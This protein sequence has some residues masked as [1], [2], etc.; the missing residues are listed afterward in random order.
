MAQMSQP[1]LKI[2][3]KI[4]REINGICDG[5]DLFETVKLRRE[6]LSPLKLSLPEDRRHKGGRNIKLKE[7]SQ[8]CRQHLWC[9]CV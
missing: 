8:Q 7:C 2:I 1:K 3:N 9:A 5:C 6:M 4:K